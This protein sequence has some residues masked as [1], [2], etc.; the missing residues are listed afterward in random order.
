MSQT[1][2]DL[3]KIEVLKSDQ[4]FLGKDPGNS[5]SEKRCNEKSKWDKRKLEWSSKVVDF[6]LE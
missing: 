2:S 3:T 1:E 4:K 6:Y 5:N